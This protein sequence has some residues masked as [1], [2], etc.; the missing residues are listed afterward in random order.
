EQGE[1][2]GLG[3]GVAVGAD[4]LSEV[5]A[6]GRYGALDPVHD[7]TR[8]V[9]SHAGS[10]AVSERDGDRRSLLGDGAL[11]V[12]HLDD[13]ASHARS[14]T[15]IL[16]RGYGPLAGRG[17]ATIGAAGQRTMEREQV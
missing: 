9:T 2:L 14:A 16:P 12:D 8:Q 4:E 15:E 13:A 10:L 6:W 7:D 3:D 1:G 5:E 11:R 17:E